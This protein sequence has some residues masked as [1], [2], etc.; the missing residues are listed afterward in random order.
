MRLSSAV[1]SVAV[2]MFG[3]DESLV[4]DLEEKDANEVVA[5]LVARGIHAA[6][7]AEKGRKPTYAV[8]VSAS[9]LTRALRL[10]QELKLP[11]PTRTTTRLVAAASNLVDSP[12]IERLRQFEAL[13]GDVEEA[14][15]SIEHVTSASVEL[16][17]PN[18]RVGVA[19]PAS[20]ASVLL[21]V[22]QPG[23][24]R[25]ERQR[26]Q[27]RELVAAAVEGLK[28]DDVAL[29]VDPVDKAVDALPPL[30]D[31]PSGTRWGALAVAFVLAGLA[32]AL[33]ALGLRDI[34]NR[35]AT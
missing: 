20:K 14:L 10:L 31:A 15:E 34:R 32:C 4:R 35:V 16:V 26:Q 25:V 6:K 23:L 33:A 12:S 7:E 11:R 13:E 1:F 5:A 30:A 28:A 21:R 24:E 17:V 18:A 27:L 3:C 19:A 2:L 29:L 9:D 22:S 8:A